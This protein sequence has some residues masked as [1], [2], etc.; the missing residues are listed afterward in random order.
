MPVIGAK[1]SQI[2]LVAL[3]RLLGQSGYATLGQFL[4][5]FVRSKVTVASTSGGSL[6]VTQRLTSL[7]Q[8]VDLLV[9][10]IAPLSIP[11]ERVGGIDKVPH[12]ADFTL[13]D[14]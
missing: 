4:R 9:S 2:D 5:D 3:N 14:E 7:E 13:I 12:S 1:L 10:G 11:H 8:K 6:E